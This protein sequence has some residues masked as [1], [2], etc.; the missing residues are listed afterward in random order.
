MDS[1]DTG[2]ARVD[3]YIRR[4][5]KRIWR[6]AKKNMRNVMKAFVK[7]QLLMK[8]AKLDAKDAADAARDQSG[9]YINEGVGCE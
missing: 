5:Q 9:T 3:R 8:D 1:V 7:Q 6:Q 4:V 2:E